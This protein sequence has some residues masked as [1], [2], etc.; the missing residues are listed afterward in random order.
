[1]TETFSIKQHMSFL[2]LS[3]TTFLL[4]IYGRSFRILY[5]V[6]FIPPF[7]FAVT[8]F[9]AELEYSGFHL[10]SIFSWGEGV[11][12]SLV[13]YMLLLLL[14][15]IYIWFAHPVRFKNVTYTFT[16][17]GMTKTGSGYEYTRPWR[18]FLKYKETSTFILLF[19]SDN[20]AHFLQKKMFANKDELNNF[21]KMLQEHVGSSQET[22]Y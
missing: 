15:T 21:R 9:M 14:P 10:R 20:D 13:I 6:F 18:G 11:L 1:M 17:W 22:I 3:K 8:G 4:S 16:H 7:I 19:I 2:E 5:F 12:I